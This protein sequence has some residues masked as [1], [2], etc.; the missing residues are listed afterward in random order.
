MSMFDGGPRAATCKAATEHAV[1]VMSGAS[2]RACCTNGL[3]W[4]CGFCWPCPKSMSDMRREANQKIKKIRF[5]DQHIAAGSSRASRRSQRRQR[6]QAQ[7]AA[8][9]ISFPM[10][11]C[12]LPDVGIEALWLSCHLLHHS[13]NRAMLFSRTSIP[14]K[15]AN[16]E[17]AAQLLV[18][19][20]ALADLSRAEA[21]AVVGFMV[22]KRV[23][24]G[25]VMIREGEATYTD[26]MMLVVEGE[27]MV[28]NDVA[29][30][31]DSIVTAIIGPGHLVGEMGVLD[32]AP[33]S[34][35][36][37]ANVDL[38]VAV[39]SRAALLKLITA[40]PPVAARLMLAISKR[41]SDRLREANRKIKTLGGVTRA[42]QQELDA[43]H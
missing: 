9:I 42:L 17:K 4:V 31:S 7:G 30:I 5:T 34:A 13:Y 10:H 37:T 14:F 1:A 24:A 25:T 22:L 29:P 36:C 28:E 15:D 18:T 11:L 32:A 20:T 27:V 39:L 19:P 3:K 12:T 38:V 6:W 26:F 23:K 8:K 40:N 41:L 16:Q 21:R 2:L 43:A 35:T 33:R